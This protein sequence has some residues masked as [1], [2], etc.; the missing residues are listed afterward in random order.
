MV[1]QAWNNNSE[2]PVDFG[3]ISLCWG[4]P[5]QFHSKRGC[6][7]SYHQRYSFTRHTALLSLHVSGFPILAIKIFNQLPSE[8]NLLNRGLGGVSS[9]TL[10]CHP[11]NKIVLQIVH[12]WPIVN[13]F[14]SLWVHNPSR[15]LIID[16][17]LIKLLHCWQELMTSVKSDK[18]QYSNPL[19]IL[20]SKFDNPCNLIQTE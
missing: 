16:L 11:K 10:S 20:H 3:L 18:L 4:Q 1:S 5:G 12:K 19:F 15:E 14:K 7:F 17:A 6:P 2:W 9:A 8:V 13:T